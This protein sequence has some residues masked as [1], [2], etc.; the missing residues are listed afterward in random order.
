MKTQ[1]SELTGTQ[2]MA[3]IFERRAVRKFRALHVEDA[4]I[5][6]IIEA[7]CMAPSAMNRQPWKFYVLTRSQS[8]DLFSKEIMHVVIDEQ[9]N[10]GFG[11]LLKLAAGAIYS[12]YYGGFKTPNLFYHA[13]IV[14]FLAAPKDNP[15]ACYDIAMCAQNMMLGARSLGLDSCP[16]GVGKYV[17]NTPSYDT[18]GIPNEEEVHLALSIGYG[19][20]KPSPHRRVRDNVIYVD[21]VGEV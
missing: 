2:T 16:I 4:M 15:W 7:G 8:I 19:D 10:S 21:R 9:L 17:G 20:E 14:I 1:P 11:G 13:P 12:F 6:K 5:E 18:L 3:T